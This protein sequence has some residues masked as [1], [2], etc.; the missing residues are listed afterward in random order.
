MIF[1][2]LRFK[3]LLDGEH[4]M[5]ADETRVF[6]EK[7]LA[8][9]QRILA[10]LDTGQFKAGDGSVIDPQTLAEVRTWA[11]HRVAECAARIAERTI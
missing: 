1:L 2:H 4:I 5:K 3:E 6:W 7:K 9:N 10:M 11:L 8:E